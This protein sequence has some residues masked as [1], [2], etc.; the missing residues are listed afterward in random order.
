M[1]DASAQYFTDGKGQAKD[2]KRFKKAR[3]IVLGNK[4]HGKA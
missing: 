3:F 1:R 2:S 4:N